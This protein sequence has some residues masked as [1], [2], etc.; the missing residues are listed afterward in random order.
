MKASVSRIVFVHFSKLLVLLLP[1][2]GAHPYGKIRP[3]PIYPSGVIISDINGVAMS[4]YFR[5]WPQYISYD[6]LSSML[7]RMFFSHS[8]TPSRKQT[9]LGDSHESGGGDHIFD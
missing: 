6:I 5:G 1:F 9:R 8:S 7:Y 4:V 2:V 3:C